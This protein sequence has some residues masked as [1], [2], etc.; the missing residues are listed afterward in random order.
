MQ[1]GV[2]KWEAP[3]RAADDVDPGKEL[4]ATMPAADLGQIVGADQEVESRGRRQLVDEVV[5]RVDGVG[6]S[7]S[8]Y[9]DCAELESVI[10]GDGQSDHRAAVACRADGSGVSVR[11]LTH[12]HEQDPVEPQNPGS[13]PRHEEVLVVNR[14]ERP[15]EHADAGRHAPW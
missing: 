5:Q 2:R 10:A 12:R 14:I 9:V 7:R 6:R 13:S 15:T 4:L 1:A 3:A 11:G 8:L